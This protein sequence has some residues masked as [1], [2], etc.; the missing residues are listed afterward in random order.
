M[1]TEDKEKRETWASRLDFLLSC[2]GCCVG[3]GNVWRFSYLCYK[4]GGG[5]FILPYLCCVFIIGF[6]ILFLEVAMGQFTRRGAV[7]MWNICPLMKGIGYCTLLFSSLECV[8]YNVLLS[9]VGYY[10]VLSFFP[11]LPWTHC[12][13]DWNT[14]NCTEGHGVNG[15]SEAA[16][17][18]LLKGPQN[19]S[20]LQISHNLSTVLPDLNGTTPSPP[21]THLVHASV[22]FWW[23]GVLRLS[24]G[25]DSPGEVSPQLLTS[26]AIFWVVVFFCVFKG[27]KWSG[28][29]VYFT[30]TFP[31]LLMLTL[32]VQALRQDGSAMGVAY[33]MT[34]QFDRLGDIKVWFDAASQVLFSYAV[35][36]AV[37]PAYA[38]YCPFNNNCFRDSIIVATTNSLTSF[39]AGFVVFAM[40]GHMAHVQQE[41]IESVAT[42]GPGLAFIVY[43]QALSLLPLPQLWSVLFF[44]MMILVGLDSQFACVEG[45]MTGV[46]DMFPRWRKWRMLILFVFIVTAFL[47]GI[48]MITQGGMYVFQLLDYY[49]FG[50]YTLQILA[51]LEVIT[52]AWVYGAS[53]FY[54]DIELMIGYKINAWV[55]ICW[56]MLT[57]VSLMVILVF[58]LATYQPLTYNKT[59]KFPPWANGLGFLMCFLVL[60]VVP[61]S[62][63]IT[64]I[65]TPGD[66]L[67]ERLRK[68]TK[69]KVDHSGLRAD[70]PE[71]DPMEKKSD[72]LILSQME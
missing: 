17:L 9:W 30:A 4:N 51:F 8:Y 25:I 45:I 21:D 2:V 35:V 22:E 54:G 70:S 48:T 29:V 59:Y 1:A 12:N 56:K 41:S 64:L 33:Y 13:H 19:Q 53:R 55:K 6:P 24:D 7:G 18:P 71:T 60:L 39:L 34:P 31:Y 37:L 3:F 44:F 62:V 20:S 43:P 32:L 42:S 57:P 46:W 5:A 68:A 14:A 47:L 36:L 69:S 26:L 15:S 10:F 58:N 28:K 16:H 49:L 27:V 23:R 38:S 66:G 61:I 72:S 11:V 40:L 52:V 63:I 67:L 65:N 50:A